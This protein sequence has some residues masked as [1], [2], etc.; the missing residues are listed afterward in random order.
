MRAG[1]VLGQHRF[2]VGGEHRAAEGGADARMQLEER[3]ARLQ[4]PDAQQGAGRGVR[5]HEIPARAEGRAAV[6]RDRQANDELHGLPEEPDLAARCHV[7]QAHGRGILAAEEL[8]ALGREGQRFEPAAAR[9]G[10]HFFPGAHVAE[11]DAAVGGRSGQVPAVGGERHRPGWLGKASQLA[12]RGHLPDP[13]RAIL[14]AGRGPSVVGRERHAGDAILMTRQFPAL[15]GSERLGARDGRRGFHGNDGSRRPLLAPDFDDRAVSARERNPIAR[16]AQPHLPFG[17]ANAHGLQVEFDDLPGLIADAHGMSAG[18]QGQLHFGIVRDDPHDVAVD[19][20]NDLDGGVL[21]G[22]NAGARRGAGKR[23][24]W[25]FVAGARLGRRPEG[26]SQQRARKTDG[27]HRNP[28]LV[29]WAMGGS[30]YSSQAN[31]I[32]GPRIPPGCGPSWR[33][34]P[35][36]PG[37]SRYGMP[38]RISLPARV[39]MPLKTVRSIVLEM[40]CCEPSA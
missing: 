22:P 5:I 23:R 2:P 13:H 31:A 24:A 4:V 38:A 29:C 9:Q 7:P 25:R 6:G 30:P 37:I 33:H 26:R 15:E 40:K 35:Q 36:P 39:A 28:P 8:V 17:R 14:A 27:S 3:L 20:D 16:D 21:R 19:M 1:R 34:G 10:L 11:R 18:E 12:A 32:S